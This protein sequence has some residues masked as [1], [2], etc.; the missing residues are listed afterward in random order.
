MG[1]RDRP[2]ASRSPCQN[3]YA[4]RLIGSIRRDCL[5]HVVVFG[6]R[7]LRHLLKSHQQYY[8]EARTHLS[9][10]KDA[11]IPRPSVRR[12][13]CP[14]WAGCTTNTYE[15]EFP[16]GTGALVKLAR[17]GIQLAHDHVEHFEIVSDQANDNRII[18]VGDARVAIGIAIFGYLQRK[19]DR[20]WALHDETRRLVD[21]GNAHSSRE[22]FWRFTDASIASMLA[23][24]PLPHPPCASLS[25]HFAMLG[26]I[27]FL[28]RLRHS[29]SHECQPDTAMI[30]ARLAGR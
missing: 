9:L 24:R 2:I 28:Q 10:Q 16:T 21:Q 4:E 7:H 13:Q 5:D 8:K 26:I 6:E 12:W 30:C 19:L 1:I 20:I 3:G 22:G 27:P 23:M 17:S 18:R 25:S 11:P 29:P 14:S 15:R